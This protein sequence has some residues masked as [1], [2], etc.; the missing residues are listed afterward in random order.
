MIINT[1]NTGPPHQLWWTE[2]DDIFD[3]TPCTYYT[4]PRDRLISFVVNRSKRRGAY[5]PDACLVPSFSLREIRQTLDDCIRDAIRAGAQSENVDVKDVH[6]HIV[7][8]REL[9][10]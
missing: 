7:E 8:I 1:C 4:W 10:R 3:E 6:A 2:R 9:S 5:Q